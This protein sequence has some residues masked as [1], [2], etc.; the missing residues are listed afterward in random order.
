MQQILQSENTA[1]KRRIPFR[2]VDSTGASVPSLTFSAGDIK[3]SKNGGAE[4][5]HAGSYTEISDGNYYYETTAGE[6][7][8]A[9]IL[10][11]RFIKSPY[12]TFYGMVQVAPDLDTYQAKTWV[13][14]GTTVDHY[15]TAWF[16]NSQPVVSG[17][18]SPTIQ[19]IKAADGADLIAVTAMTQ[20]GTTGLYRY[21]ESTNRTSSG[22]AYMI[23]PVAT[24]EGTSRTW[25]QPVGRDS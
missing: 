9:G 21:D 14:K 7:D 19:V 8:T 10:S 13:F 15:E 24:I 20:I 17:I 12:K 18:T 25:Y 1:S 3:L 22:I 4:S 5:N 23:K 2:I 16:K 11:I 6:V